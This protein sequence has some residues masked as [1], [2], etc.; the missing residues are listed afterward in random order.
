MSRLKKQGWRRNN[1]A[2]AFSV[3]ASFAE[4]RKRQ[5]ANLFV[6]VTKRMQQHA[7]TRIAEV[8]QLL[9]SEL[10]KHEELHEG[11]KGSNQG[12]T[13]GDDGQAPTQVCEGVQPEYPKRG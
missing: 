11:A 3:E 6:D 13:Q 7:A 5:G 8:K 10:A 12:S 9:E 4:L 1:N 2:K